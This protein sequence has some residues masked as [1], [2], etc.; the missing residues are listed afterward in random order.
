M[1]GPDH[2]YGTWSRDRW[3]IT[4]A[5][6]FCLQVLLVVLLSER[7]LPSPPR[8]TRQ[9]GLAV[10]DLRGEGLGFARALEP[11]DP[12]LFALPS[13]RGRNLAGRRAD[14]EADGLKPWRDAPPVWLRAHSNWFG[15]GA[16]GWT[17][18]AGLTP[19]AVVEKPGPQLSE[20]RP[21]PLP[22]PK[23]SRLELGPELAERGLAAAFAVP[24]LSHSNVLAPT[25]IQVC[26]EP[27]GSV[28][29]ALV[30]RSSGLK[31]ADDQALALAWGA[32]FRR[33]PAGVA[34][35]P[36]GERMWGRMVFHWHVVGPDG[37]NGAPGGAP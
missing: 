22:M 34:V 29:S 31:S 30:L 32:R 10:L 2:P 24:A 37:R 1:K 7:G 23:A 5:G 4:G 14:R 15:P 36:P 28:Y 8:M 3:L 11:L 9:P 13:S 16:V 6:L 26:V 18:A 19:R 35:P 25:Q 27:D 33:L 12:L 21:A 20:V 17:A